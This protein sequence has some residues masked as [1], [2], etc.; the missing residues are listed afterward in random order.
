MPVFDKNVVPDVTD[1][2]ISKAI[3]LNSFLN[4]QVAQFPLAG[5]RMFLQ[6]GTLSRFCDDFDGPLPWENAR[7]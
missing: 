4:D 7:C 1:A 2:L 3:D 6:E 5:F